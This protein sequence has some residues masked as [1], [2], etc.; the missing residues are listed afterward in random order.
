MDTTESSFLQ[1][2]QQLLSDV[3]AL[4][5]HIRAVL[6]KQ[7]TES[8][9]SFAGQPI[10]ATQ[11]SAVLF[12]L[13]ASPSPIGSTVAEPC[14]I[15]NKRSAKVRQPG[16]LC[17]PGGSIAPRLDPLIASLLRLPGSPLRRWKPWSQWRKNHLRRSRKLALLFAT[18]L[19]ESVE[20]MRLN[21]LGVELLGPLPP[22]N[23]VMFQRTIYP[24]ACWVCG[25]K[26]FFPNWEV[27][28]I[29]SIPILDLLDPSRYVRY[30]L[31]I[32]VPSKSAPESGIRDFACFLHRCGDRTERLW[33]ATFR[34]AMTFL[35]T[36]FNFRPPPIGSLPTV[37]GKIDENYI[38]PNP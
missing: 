13:A 10:H 9:G 11:A 29:V 38:H 20:E 15:L 28:Q 36:V 30:R 31:R 8:V 17:C 23:L 37:E 2:S 1:P 4:L 22:E 32:D 16:D 33:G 7:A 14:L 3:P 18:G 35:D 27:E 25:Q 19:R 26:K 6:Q 24:L 34:I 21:P 12:L 5:Q